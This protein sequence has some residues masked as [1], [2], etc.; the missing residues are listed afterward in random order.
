MLN[1]TAELVINRENMSKNKR[2]IDNP[3]STEMIEQL[4]TFESLEALYKAIPF[5]REDGGRN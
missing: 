2:I 3:S 4:Q 5:A 1:H